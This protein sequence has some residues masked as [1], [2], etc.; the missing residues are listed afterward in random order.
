MDPAT[1]TTIVTAAIF[2]GVFV[3]M[4]CGYVAASLF[5]GPQR[6]L[7]KRVA[8]IRYRYSPTARLGLSAT[9]DGTNTAPDADSNIMPGGLG[10]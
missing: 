4:G 6:Q 9:L 2:I 5:S 8:K 10:S 1:N 3:L 7:V